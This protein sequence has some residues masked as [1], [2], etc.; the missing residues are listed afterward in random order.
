MDQPAGSDFI[1]I[2]QA[3]V[4]TRWIHFAAIMVLFGSAF[5]WFIID[6]KFPHARRATENLLRAAA[7]VAAIAGL[8][9]LGEIMANM[10]GG[11]D[12]LA[13]RDTLRLFFYE[14]QFGPVALFRLMLLAAALV[15]AMWPWRNRV[16]LAAQMLI[17]ALLLIDQAWFGHAAQGSGLRGAAM[18]GVYCIHALA[19]AA[20]IGGL[21]PLLMA[22]NEASPPRGEELR[23]AKLVMLS[24]YSTMALIAVV[25]I[26]VTGLVNAGFRV[27][28][29]PGKAAW[30]DYGI[31]LSIKLALVAAMLVL[32]CFN[33]LV[34]MPRLRGASGDGAAP[35]SMLSA[36]VA[37]ELIL[38][39]LVI[40]A[41]ALLGV[42]P[43]P[44]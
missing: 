5:F 9:W 10:A 17:G 3:L 41:V 26:L 14:T 40:G 31:I 38:G 28:F 33:R 27:D 8:G 1:P 35:I 34:A 13:D 19:A 23:Q 25:L 30:G 22:L 24:R 32:A 21:P 44:G 2:F 6:N 42:T 16:W 39:A 4:V 29:A 36:S 20:W 11:W 7:F 37:I 12:R 18:I 15:T 43:P